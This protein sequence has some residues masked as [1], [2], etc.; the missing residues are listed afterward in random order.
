[1]KN[2]KKK[3][4]FDT[5]KGNSKKSETAFFVLTQSQNHCQSTLRISQ[6]IRFF[7]QQ[8]SEY[9]AQAITFRIFYLSPKV[10]YLER[11]TRIQNE[12]HLINFTVHFH[13]QIQTFNECRIL[14]FYIVSP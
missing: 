10:A 14:R 12:I 7:R 6:L 8:N 13:D 3:N 11:I 9:Q 2:R 1:M 5:F 4:Y